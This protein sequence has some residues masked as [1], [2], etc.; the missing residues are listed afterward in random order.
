MKPNYS[1]IY[2]DLIMEQD[3]EK[4]KDQYINRLIH[5]LNT[6]EDVIRL[7]EKLFKNSTENFKNNQKLR[8]YDYKTIINILKYQKNIIFQI[9]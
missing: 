5:N 9:S 6:S 4:L 8:N 3:P 1:K 2:Y 7:N